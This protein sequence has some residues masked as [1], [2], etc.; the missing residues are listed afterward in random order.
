VETQNYNVTFTAPLCAVGGA[1]QLA[2]ITT[3]LPRTFRLE[4][5]KPAARLSKTLDTDLDTQRARTTK[6]DGTCRHPVKE[7]ST[8]RSPIL[9]ITMTLLSAVLGVTF[10]DSME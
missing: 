3:P 5:W 6:P 8:A 1:V 7:I 2:A 10:A 9:L 4:A